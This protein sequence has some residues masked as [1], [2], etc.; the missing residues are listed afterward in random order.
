MSETYVYNGTEVVLTGRTAKRTIAMK[1]P[2]GKVTHEPRI[3]TIHEITPADNE[4]GSWKK[5]IRIEELYE[6]QNF[7]EANNGLEEMLSQSRASD[8]VKGI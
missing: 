6:I 2:R 5:W 8:R 3:D 7:E 1:S 4:F